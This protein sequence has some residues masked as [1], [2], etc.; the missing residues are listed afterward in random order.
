MKYKSMLFIFNLLPRLKDL[1]TTSI[2]MILMIILIVIVSVDS[3]IYQI[4]Q[5]DISF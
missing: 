3:E 2:V 4:I 5:Q 1:S